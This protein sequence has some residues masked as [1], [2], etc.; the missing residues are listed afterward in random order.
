MP[1][2]GRRCMRSNPGGGG[3]G[4]GRGGAAAGRAARLIGEG[5]AAATDV[6]QDMHRAITAAPLALLAAVHPVGGALSAHEGLHDG[7]CL[8][9]PQRHG[10]SAFSSPL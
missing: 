5:V 4:G 9:S 3:S 6:V 1:A 8:G 10:S 7:V 2:V